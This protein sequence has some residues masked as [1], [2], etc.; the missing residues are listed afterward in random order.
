MDRTPP[1]PKLQRFTIALAF[2]CFVA[3]GIGSGLLGVAWPSMRGA[4]GLPLDALVALLISSTAGFVV[5]SV[6]AGRVIARIGLGWF[7]LLTNLLAAGGVIGYAVAPG[8]WVLVAFGVLAGWGGGAIDTGLNIFVASTRTVRIM[9]WMHGMFGVGATLGP[10]IMTTVVSAGISWRFGY[11]IAALVHLSLGLLSIPVLRRMDFRGM[12]PSAADGRGQSS[13]EASLTT[14]RLPIVLLSIILFL[15]YTGVETTAGQWSYSLFTEARGMSPYLAG[16]SIS[17][18][19]A[20]L[21]MGR[22]LFG[23]AAVRIGIPRLLRLSMIGTVISAGV[24]LLRAPAAS[25]ISIGFMGLS[26]SAIFPTLTADTPHRAGA[27]HAANAIG[28]QT[29]AASI[30]FAILPGVA[31]LM[32]ARLGLE[33]LGPYL[34]ITSALMLLMNEVATRLVQRNIRQSKLIDARLP[35]D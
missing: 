26:L 10:L 22:I 19:W 16:I 24:F 35:T 15:L 25:I 31:G 5:G 4:F 18:F 11:V 27:V 8:W 32:A 14:L 20:M 3:L 23:A 28:F 2:A 7:L 12:T 33:T 13:A 1:S 9:N 6:T 34:V 21:T 29:G 17:L 30:G